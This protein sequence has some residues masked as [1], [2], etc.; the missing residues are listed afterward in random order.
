METEVSR[1]VASARALRRRTT[2]A[3]DALWR[4][5]RKD[6]LGVRFRRQHG[7]GPFVVDFCCLPLRLVVEVDGDIHDEDDVSEQDAWRTEYLQQGGFTVRRFRNDDVLHHPDR[8]IAA[9]RSS[10]TSRTPQGSPSP[11]PVAVEP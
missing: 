6:Q 11:G 5:L 3:E 2:L 4:H 9:I 8:V 10:M 1:R 7:I